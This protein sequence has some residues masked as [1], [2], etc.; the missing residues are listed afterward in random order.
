MVSRLRDSL[1]NKYLLHV[2]LL[3]G[4]A[5]FM[6]VLFVS[7]GVEADPKNAFLF[8]YSLPRL[9][10]SGIAL[11]TAAGLFFL[12]I[13]AGLR[14]S[15]KGVVDGWVVRY[16]LITGQII[17]LLAGLAGMIGL[18]PA[19]FLG[20]YGAFFVR[21]R[22]FLFVICLYPAHFSFY[23]LRNMK[24]EWDKDSRRVF[25]VTPGENQRREGKQVKDK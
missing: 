9:I 24:I 25:V 19:E 14:E 1:L 22:W 3:L 20:V 18:L 6:L 11:V 13:N 12:T 16:P 23:F 5:E 2:L 15:C 4:S 10:I 7:L 17:V 21:L 8:G